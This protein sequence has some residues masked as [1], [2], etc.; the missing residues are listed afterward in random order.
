[1]R[2]NYQG[3]IGIGT[4]SPILTAFTGATTKVTVANTTNVPFLIKSYSSTSYVSP[5]F[6][7]G[8]SRGGAIGTESATSSGDILGTIGFEG[9]NTSSSVAAAAY[10]RSLQDGAG[11]ATYIP[12]SLL[13]FTGTNAALPAERMRINKSKS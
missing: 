13:F 1:M 4:S 7:L 10:I 11:G 9:V 12:G 6:S 2:I 8:K 3:N 5:V